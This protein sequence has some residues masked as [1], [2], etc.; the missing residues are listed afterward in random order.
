MMTCEMKAVRKLRFWSGL[1]FVLI[2]SVTSCKEGSNPESSR[3][4]TTRGV[5][6]PAGGPVSARRVAPRGSALP[7]P[8]D[9]GVGHKQTDGASRCETI[10]RISEP[11]RC[12][13]SAECKP[14][15]LSMLAAGVCEAEMVTLF[16]CLAAQ[17]LKNWECDEDGIGAIRDPY[18]GKE[19]ERL[20][21]CFERRLKP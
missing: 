15:C 13:D 11:L 19:Q 20:A 14:R 8:G 5:A 1:P 18:C 16:D 12:K 17:P 7:S 9:A 10:C 6:Q 2:M 3:A 4:S 21:I